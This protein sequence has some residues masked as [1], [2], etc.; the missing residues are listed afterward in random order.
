VIVR[1]AARLLAALPVTLA[2]VAVAATPGVAADRHFDIVGG[3]AAPAGAWPSTAYLRGAFHTRKG[4]L[5]EFACTGSVVAPQWILTAAHCV[6]GNPGKPPERMV[7]TLGVTDYT[8]PARQDIAVD[9]FM[10]DPAYDPNSETADIA[11]VHLSQPT[12]QPAMALATT[13]Q[14]YSS[15]ANVPNAAGW[16]DVDQSGTQLTTTLQQAYLQVQAPEACSS[17]IS[18]FDPSTQA[19]A[20]TPGATGACFGDSGGPLVEFDAAGQPALWG[21][22]SYGPQVDAGLAPCSVKLPAVY[23]WI[24]AFG[25]FIQATITSSPAAGSPAAEPVA[26]VPP[27]ACAKATKRLRATRAAERTALRRLRS[28]RR[29]PGTVARGR[30]R[31]LSHRYHTLR[32]RRIRAAAAA[33]RRCG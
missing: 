15:P 31:A 5:R 7:A 22:T 6:I 19:C 27:A 24:P 16:G 11:L 18:G 28:A 26:Y 29:H 10:A 12:A 25:D 9:R 23:A 17:L 2:C 1:R 8:D 20:G 14:P 32:S 13:A 4:H 21:I 3:A 30:V 33:A